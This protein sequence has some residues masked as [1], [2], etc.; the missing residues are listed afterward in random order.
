MATVKQIF[1]IMNAVSKQMYGESAPAVTNI[2]GMVSFGERV[3]SSDKDKELFTNT[4]VDRINYI[5]FSN[6]RTY[7]IGEAMMLRLSWE[8]G[9]I[10]QKIYVDMPEAV[11]NNSWEISKEGYKP[12]RVP[13]IQPTVK[14]K[15]FSS[16]NTFEI[17]MT[18]PDFLWNTA[19]TN[20]RDAARLIDAS[21]SAVRNAAVTMLEATINLTRAS[22]IARKLEGGKKCCA[23]NLLPIYNAKK[24]TNLKAANWEM[25]KD[26]LRFMSVEIMKWCR[27]MRRMSTLFNE[28]GYKRF[29]P[30]SNL[31]LTLHDD[32]ASDLIG[33]MESDTY[34]NEL[35]KLTNYSTVPYWQFSGE[36]DWADSSAINVQVND[37]VTVNASGIVAVAY[38]WE[39]MAVMMENRK[40]TSER[41]NR[42]EYTD[43]FHKFNRG[44]MNDLSENGIVFYVAD[45]NYTP[46]GNLLAE[47]VANYEGSRLVSAVPKKK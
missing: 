35:V 19:F 26:F 1:T 27:R 22:F 46:S 29:T 31:V 18:I 39:A 47:T 15:L 33:F 42:D 16:M 14:Q 25:D 21:F 43:Y 5:I 37:T 13:V 9:F 30:S 38:D 12:N 45:E 41:N 24:G 17:P 40:V 3:L 23:I 11:A 8:Y 34:H 28:E 36:Y 32:F 44:L 7:D 20:A 2:D 4:L 10:L 6:M